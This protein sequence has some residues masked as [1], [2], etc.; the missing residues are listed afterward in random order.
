MTFDYLKSATSTR[1]VSTI[2]ACELSCK[3]KYH[4]NFIF[5]SLRKS[6]AIMGMCTYSSI[7]D[8]HC[9]TVLTA[10][11]FSLFLNSPCKLYNPFLYITGYVVLTPQSP[12]TR[13][14]IYHS[15]NCCIIFERTYFSRGQ[16]L[17]KIKVLLNLHFL[18][19]YY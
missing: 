17:S 11:L 7:K 3:R 1:S 19:V 4:I 15:Q 10:E 16:I 13:Y 14:P 2:L 18:D 9:H 8:E 6:N 5:F 12:L